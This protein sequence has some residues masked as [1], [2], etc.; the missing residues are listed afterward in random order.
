MDIKQIES[1]HIE[2]ARNLGCANICDGMKSLKMEF[3]GCMTYRMQP[4]DDSLV[5]AG[6]AITVD[7]CDGDNFPIHVAI[8]GAKPGYVLVIDGK[9]YDGCAY[10]GDL[11]GDASKAIGLEGIVIDGLVRDKQGLKNLRLPVYSKGYSPKSP[12]KKGPGAI[13]VPIVCDGVSVNPGDLVVGDCDGVVVVPHENVKEVLEA[14]QVKYDYEI[15]R[16]ERIAEYSRRKKESLELFDLAPGWVRKM[17][18]S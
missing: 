3:N 15:Q 6:T 14:A 17:E 4:N 16:R 7:T 8:Y 5:M 1:K 9:G 11:M 2:Q 12:N 10:L 13:N 18:K